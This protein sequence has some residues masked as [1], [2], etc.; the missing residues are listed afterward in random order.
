MEGGKYSLLVF[1]CVKPLGKSVRRI[2]L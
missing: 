2:K 1:A